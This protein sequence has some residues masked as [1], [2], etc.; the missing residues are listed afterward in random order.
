MDIQYVF[1]K[2]L[3]QHGVTIYFYGT[4]SIESRWEQIRAAIVGSNLGPTKFGTRADGSIETYAEVWERTTGKPLQE[5]A[6]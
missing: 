2:R 6:A 4:T 5:K 3:K 1:Q